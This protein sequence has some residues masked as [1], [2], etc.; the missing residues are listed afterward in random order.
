MN[1]LILR[2]FYCDETCVDTL[3]LKLM[4]PLE[5]VIVLFRIVC[6][7]VESSGIESAVKS[8]ESLSM[9]SGD[10]D[11]SSAIVNTYETLD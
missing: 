9:S 8:L 6:Y 3:Q 2:L 1:A 7:E 5:M 10:E 11:L 4:L